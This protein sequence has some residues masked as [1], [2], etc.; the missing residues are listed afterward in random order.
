M[1]PFTVTAPEH[2]FCLSQGGTGNFLDADRVDCLHALSQAMEEATVTWQP[3]NFR[4]EARVMGICPACFVEVS[5]RRLD[6]KSWS[7]K[8]GSQI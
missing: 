8:R 7:L 5:K 3:G 4:Q 1:I 6:T 2:E